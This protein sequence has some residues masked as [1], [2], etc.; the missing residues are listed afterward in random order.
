MFSVFN[1]GTKKNLLQLD[2]TIPV[3]YKGK[4]GF[5][6]LSKV[7]A[8]GRKA[9]GPLKLGKLELDHHFK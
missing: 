1:D 8:R 9:L 7:G 6:C 2:G 4:Q 5:S 3:S